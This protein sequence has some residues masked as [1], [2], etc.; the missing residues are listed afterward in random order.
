VAGRWDELRERHVADWYV[1]QAMVR[2]VADIEIADLLDVGTGTGRM[3]EVFADRIQRGLGIDT[4]QKMLTVARSRL[5]ASGILNCAVRPGNA[6]DL[7]VGRGT[8]DVAVIHHVLHFLDEPERAVAQ[9]A[10][11]LRPGGRLLIVDFAPHGLETLR[12]DHAHVWL[13]FD[14]HEVSDWLRES[15]LALRDTV[16]LV[17]TE[18]QGD[19][20]LTVTLW[21]AERSGARTV[22]E[23]AL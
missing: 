14:G 11:A 10:Q 16:H 1:E 5:S 13:G 6:H 4:S 20:A 7:G 19:N 18:D 23:L 22:D 17:P 15:G 2:A 3:L 12:I 21:V 9:A 8:F